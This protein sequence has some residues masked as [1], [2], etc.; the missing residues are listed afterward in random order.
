MNVGTKNLNQKRKN[1][2]KLISLKECRLMEE[3]EK[4]LQKMHGTLNKT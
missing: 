2:K 1:T 4:V 3:M